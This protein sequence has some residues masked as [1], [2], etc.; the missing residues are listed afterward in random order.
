MRRQQAKNKKVI[1]SVTNDLV[2]DNR[3]HK[4]ST[5]LTNAGYN[6]LLIGRKRKNSKE[7]NRIYT[8]KRLKLLFNSKAV[9]YAEYNIRLFLYLI[10]HKADILLSNDTDSLPANYYASKLKNIPLVFDAH[11]LFPEVPELINRPGIQKI[12]RKIE[13]KFIPKVNNSYTVCQSIADYYN[14][15][16][17][18]NMQVVRNF[19]ICRTNDSITKNESSKTNIRDKHDKNTK[20]LLYQGAVNV[21]RGLEYIID[22][23]PYLENV[24]FYIV[25]DGDIVDNIKQRAAKRDVANRVFFTG[26]ISL[27]DLSD[28]TKQADLGI[29][30]IE[31]KGLSYYYALPNR[32]GD[33]AQAGLPFLTVGFPEMKRIVDDYNIGEI[34]NDL[35][36]QHLANTINK[37]LEKWSKM[38]KIKKNTLFEKAKTELCWQKEETVLISIFNSIG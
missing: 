19:P 36:P 18:I 38:D 28:I 34:I 1:I 8:T 31:N 35:A 9:F 23:L 4:V 17:K 30:I 21:G 3:V 15:R 14:H 7:I 27:D 16:Y 11:E 32:I 20:I 24:I 13:D 29:N 12:W 25:G 26:R 6:V 2:A 37:A 22:A 5:S 33:F 10:F